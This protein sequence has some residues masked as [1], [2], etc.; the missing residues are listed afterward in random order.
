VIV[1]NYSTLANAR[2]EGKDLLGATSGPAETRRRS[3]KRWQSGRAFQKA[4]IVFQ[5]AKHRINLTAVHGAH[6]GAKAVTQELQRQCTRVQA[7]EREVRPYTGSLEQML[8]IGPDVLQEKVTEHQAF[9]AF[10]VSA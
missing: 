9:D 5:S 8:A 3:A 1:I 2:A 7:P 10:S 6:R 4:G